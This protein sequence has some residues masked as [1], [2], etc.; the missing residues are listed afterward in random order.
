VVLV[1]QHA[2]ESQTSPRA[3]GLTSKADAMPV[4]ARLRHEASDAFERFEDEMGQ[5]IESPTERRAAWL[6]S[7]GATIATAE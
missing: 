7:T 5:R 1:D 6:P 4:M 3:A 2:L